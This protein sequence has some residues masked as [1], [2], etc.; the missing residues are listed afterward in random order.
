MLTSALIA[1]ARQVKTAGM[2]DAANLTLRENIAAALDWWREAGV[3]GDLQDAAQCWMAVKTA[4]KLPKA[5]AQRVAPSP[6]AAPA[7]P[8]MIDRGSWP[9]QFGSFTQWWLT[10]AWLDEGRISSRV[11]PRGD[12]GAELMILVAEP[13]REDSEKLLSGPQGRLLAAMLSAFGIRENTAYVAS[14]LPRHT[15][16]ADWDAVA[17]RGLGQL[18]CHHITLAAPQRLIVFGST[19][20]SLLGHDSANNPGGVAEFAHGDCKV[21][22]LAARDLAVLRERPRWK[23]ALW[24]NWLDWTETK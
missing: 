22:M 7:S 1:A 9:Q 18:A 23:A 14:V 11:P 21:P 15:P 24:Q 16:H 10:E 4:E 19:I 2:D 17:A 12:Q 20:L 8:S 13:E 5:E 6:A 3:D